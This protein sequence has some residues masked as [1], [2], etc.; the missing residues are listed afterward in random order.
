MSTFAQLCALPTP[1]MAILVEAS[2]DR[3]VS[4]LS[5]S[6][7]TQRWSTVAGRFNNPSNVH[8]FGGIASVGRMQR[9]LGTDGTPAAGTMSLVLD[10]TDGAFDWLTARSTVESTVFLCRFRVYVAVFD[11]ANPTDN[12]VQLAGTFI[13]LDYPERDESRVYLELADDV[14]GDAADLSLSPSLSSWL[15]HASTT[16]GNTPWAA[17]SGNL[18]PG[19]EFVTDPTKPL[20]LAFGTGYI[21]LLRAVSG[22]LRYHPHVICCTTNTTL[23]A[24]MPDAFIADIKTASGQSVPSNE[25]LYFLDRSPFSITRDGRTWRIW[26]VQFDTTGL[27]GSAWAMNTV[28]G[29]EFGGPG[30]SAAAIDRKAFADAFFSKLGPLTCKAFPLSAHTYP[31]VASG[32]PT[33]NPPPTLLVDVARDL[34]EQ[35]CRGA[36]EADETSFDAVAAHNPS[37]RAAVY[38]ANIGAFSMQRSE[39]AVIA[40]SGQTRGILK[41]LCQ[42]GGFDLTTLQ[43]GQVAALA[44]TATYEAY[45]GAAA[46]S[47]L[48]LDET[49]IVADSLR[50]RTPSQGQR[51]APYNRVFIDVGSASGHRLPGRHGPFDHGDDSSGNIVSWGRPMTRI[52]DVTYADI[53]EGYGNDF[54]SLGKTGFELLLSQFPVESLVRP[55]ISFRY[56]LEALELDLGDYFIL[57]LTRGGQTT[58]LDTYEDVMW[59]TEAITLVPDTGQV[60]VVAVWAGD[61]LADIPFLLDNEPSITRTSSGSMS[62]IDTAAGDN[63]VALAGAGDFVAAGVEVGDILVLQD[64][65]E[66]TAGFERNRGIRITTVNTGDLNLAETMASA[67]TVSTWKILRGYTT[68]PVA[69]DPGYADGGRMY[70]K[71]ADDNTSGVFSDS[72]AANKML[73]G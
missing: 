34:L 48:Q 27:F 73:G 68:Y 4:V 60:E 36:V 56:G 7:V 44:N 6:G 3:F 20:P 38:I 39:P 26:L 29:G 30:T 18:A 2:T 45:V 5:V 40:E 64:S 47:A 66:A 49:R 51:W 12:Q 32:T 14:L 28:L 24:S 41:G 46:L 57:S 59:K 55:V 37:S 13:P 35:Y 62:A 43:A 52:I 63:N 22:N 21:P 16:S 50:V 67:V 31:T 72:A 65:S 15:N 53:G 71:A 33:N 25:S 54:E 23:T 69:G 42:A 9:S 70:G 1:G 17:S 61:V 10:N 11:P 58:L 19:V 8:Y